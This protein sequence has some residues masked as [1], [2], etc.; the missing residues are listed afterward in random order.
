MAPIIALHADFTTSV[1]IWI[2]GGM[3]TLL[4]CTFTALRVERESLTVSSHLFSENNVTLFPQILLLMSLM[5]SRSFY[6]CEYCGKANHFAVWIATIMAALRLRHPNGMSTIKIDLEHSTV[7]DLQQNIC[8]ITDIL[9]SQQEGS[10]LPCCADLRCLR[11]PAVKSGYPRPQILE[12]IPELP[13]SSL[14][15][16]AV[17]S[18]PYS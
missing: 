3:L 1:P 17:R 8:S 11:M 9:P 10:N 13:L 14:G 15:L 18:H 12:M 7:H 4:L 2:A 16:K 6:G 5:R